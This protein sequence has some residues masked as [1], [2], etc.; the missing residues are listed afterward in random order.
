VIS[1]ARSP[2]AKKQSA[3]PSALCKALKKAHE[4]HSLDLVPE[5]FLDRPFRFRAVLCPEEITCLGASPPRS[6]RRRYAL[7]PEAPRDRRC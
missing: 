1:H 3:S 7:A 5:F 4:S 6:K 2:S